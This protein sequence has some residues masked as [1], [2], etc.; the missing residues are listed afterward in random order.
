MKRLGLVTLG[1]FIVVLAG[2]V[3]ARIIGASRNEDTWPTIVRVNANK[4]S[5]VWCWQKICPGRSSIAEAKNAIL[6]SG[7]KLIIDYS[8][9]LRADY[10]EGYT[11][12]LGNNENKSVPVDQIQISFSNGA[13]LGTLADV[14]L[15]FGTPNLVVYDRS[16]GYLIGQPDICFEGYL[17]AYVI[18]A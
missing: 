9:Q 11:V 13:N 1:L 5:G 17:C 4:V 3:V 15:N 18:G 10:P 12:V 14:V 7:G 8:D 6:A 16:R 2:I